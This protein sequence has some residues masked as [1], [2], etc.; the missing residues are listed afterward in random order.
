MHANKFYD[1]NPGINPFPLLARSWNRRW[2][3]FL[4][5]TA[6]K[7]SRLGPE[8]GKKAQCISNRCK[9][10]FKRKKHFGV[11]CTLKTL[12]LMV[13]II[14]CNKPSHESKHTCV[15]TH[16]ISQMATCT[17]HLPTHLTT[18]FKALVTHMDNR[19]LLQKAGTR[20]RLIADFTVVNRTV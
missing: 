2:P 1:I 13:K 3:D 17:K 4:T 16:V 11:R 6:C 8:K 7:Q 14:N 12:M 9:E 19:M 5:F 20:E 10:S 15:Y 18:E